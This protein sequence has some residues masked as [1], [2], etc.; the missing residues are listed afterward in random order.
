MLMA[1][2]NRNPGSFVRL[3]Q[4]K[5]APSAI[6]WGAYDRHAL[7]RLPLPATTADG[8]AVSPPTIEFRLPD[9]SSHPYLLLAGIAQAMVEARA[10][11]DLGPLLERTSVKALKRGA[12]T[13]APVPTRFLEVAEALKASRAALEAGGVFPPVLL[14]RL[15]ERLRA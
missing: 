3:R 9:G 4:A 15:I 5:E 13:A 1:F 8:R 7:V 2:G 14:D 6:T 11:G 10:S 12:G